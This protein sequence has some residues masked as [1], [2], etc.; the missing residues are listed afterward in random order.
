MNDW[1][2]TLELFITKPFDD[3]SG[4]EWKPKKQRRS[5]LYECGEAVRARTVRRMIQTPI[6]PRKPEIQ[7]KRLFKEK[8]NERSDLETLIKERRAAAFS[9]IQRSP[10]RQGG[11]IQTAI[12]FPIPIYR[13]KTEN[14]PIY[15][16]GNHY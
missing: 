5:E 1:D 16:Y 11:R 15:F 7:K 6:T 2:D 9:A 10:Q 4:I 14:K 13:A 3:I 8:H 12:P